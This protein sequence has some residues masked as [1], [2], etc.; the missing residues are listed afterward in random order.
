[1][2]KPAPSPAAAAAAASGESSGPGGGTYHDSP[3]YIAYL[4][5]ACNF[6][7]IAFSRTLHYQFLTWYFHGMPF[8][9]W[10]V[11]AAPS[12][13]RVALLLAVEYA[14]NV[15]DASGAAT[16]TSSAVLQAAHMLLLAG[17]ALGEVPSPKDGFLQAQTEGEE[18]KRGAGRRR[19]AK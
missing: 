5:F 11:R 2:P 18:A 8:L 12:V 14:F 6:V 4:L 9:L 3:A 17:L 7:G 19:A 10:R 1:V 13:V 16:A 15:G